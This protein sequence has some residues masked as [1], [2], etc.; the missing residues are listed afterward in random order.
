[1]VGSLRQRR[2]GSWELRV[3]A[4]RDETTGRPRYVSR[5]VR[6]DR[7]DAEREL[8]LLVTQVKDSPTSPTFGTVAELCDKWWAYSSPNLAPAVATEYRRLLDRRV[9]PALGAVDLHGLHTKDLDAWYSELLAVGGVDGDGLSPGSVRR[10]HSVVHRALEQGIAWGW[11]AT[12]PAARASPP[13]AHRRRLHLPTV[14]EISD[15][16][17]AAASVNRALPILLRLAAVTGARRGELCALR[18]CHL[19]T[20]HNTLHI[21]GAIAETGHG[22]VERPTKTHAERRLCLDPDTVVQLGGLRPSDAGPSDRRFIFTHDPA[23]EIPWRPNYVTLA[24]GRLARQL[25][26]PGIRLHD[27]R[28]FAATSMLLNGIDMRTT[29][30]RLG[31][32]RASTT[33]DIY[34][35]YTIPADQ[36][37]AATLADVLNRTRHKAFTHPDGEDGVRPGRQPDSHRR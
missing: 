36:H 16:I 10:V 27:L 12:N 29:A 21:A 9:I 8:A 23:G 19:D 25:D 31:H 1:M 3:H 26:I 15:L 5:T 32:A 4:G 22:I 14:D 28:H 20:E 35:H 7:D 34:A 37:A 2:P 30:G 13:P 11:I 17:D 6:G 24:F 33:V 18:W